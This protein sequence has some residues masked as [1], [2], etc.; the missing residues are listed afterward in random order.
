MMNKKMKKRIGALALAAVMV[1]G[2]ITASAATESVKAYSSWNY[3][4]VLSGQTGQLTT[5]VKKGSKG[6][7]T[8]YIKDPYIWHYVGSH[9]FSNGG[10]TTTKWDKYGS[11]KAKWKGFAE[12]CKV[13][14]EVY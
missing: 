6:Q 2:S 8:M 7:G 9:Y 1:G 5:S 11:K 13:T 3:T 10:K 12:N 14:I 4:E